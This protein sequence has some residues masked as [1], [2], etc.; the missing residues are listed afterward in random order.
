MS[1]RLFY[2]LHAHQQMAERGIA[3]ADVRAVLSSGRLI[4]ETHHL[5]APLPRR[6]GLNG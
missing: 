3:P 6:S 5:A 4:H 1:P 2:R